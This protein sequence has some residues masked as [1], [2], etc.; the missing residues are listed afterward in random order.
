MHSLSSTYQAGQPAATRGQAL[1]LTVCLRAQTAKSVDGLTIHGYELN[2]TSAA[3][4]QANA[5]SFNLD[6]TY[7]VPSAG[8]S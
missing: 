8:N 4:A 3:L 7:Q 2:P 6:N 5:A 1:V